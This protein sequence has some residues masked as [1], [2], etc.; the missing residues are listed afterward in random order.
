MLAGYQHLLFAGRR[1]QWDEAALDLSADAAAVPALPRDARDRLVRL[2]AGF[3]VAEAAVAEHLT[4]FVTRSAGGDPDAHACFALQQGDEARHA[5]FFTR[6][7]DEVFGLP[8]DRHG[9]AGPAIVRLFEDDLPAR[10]AALAGDEHAFTDAV[11]LYHL[12]L[13]GIVFAVGQEALLA[14]LDALGSLPGTREGVARVQGDERWHVGLGVLHLRT[15]GRPV[16]VEEPAA[17]AAAAWGPQ[18]ATAERLDRVL[19]AHRRRVGFVPVAA[20][21]GRGQEASASSRRP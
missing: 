14:Q 17:R 6:V 7:A 15:L 10:A 18:I 9:L 19:R 12:V 20:G 4:P 3:C 21:R 2:V 1:L 16:D 5:R 8:A 13:E 11:G